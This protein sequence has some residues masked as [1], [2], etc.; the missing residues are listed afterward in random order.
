M[1][2]ATYMHVGS[3]GYDLLMGEHAWYPHRP[4]Y[5]LPEWGLT[6]SRQAGILSPTPPC[7][8]P[9]YS[10]SFSKLP[11]RPLLANLWFSPPPPTDRSCASIS[12]QHAWGGAVS[13]F[14]SRS[15]IN[16]RRNGRGQSLGEHLLWH[17][18]SCTFPS[19]PDPGNDTSIHVLHYPDIDWA[20]PPVVS[21]HHT[22]S[23]DPGFK[24]YLYY[25]LP[26]WNDNRFH[27]LTILA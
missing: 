24:S 9:S 26:A 5:P 22:H 16:M 2:S 17:W 7:Q 19:W 18:N 8:L 12:K 13:P 25:V 14:L 3:E 27:G 10:Y 6:P 21:L 1:S 11:S 23:S 4:S 20:N 15:S